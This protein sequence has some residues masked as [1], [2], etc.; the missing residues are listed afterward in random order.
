MISV[1]TNGTQGKQGFQSKCNNYYLSCDN[2]SA[3]GDLGSGSAGAER[4]RRRDEGAGKTREGVLSLG[5]WVFI[6]KKNSILV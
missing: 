2:G 3:G 6:W 1:S 4:K 5:I